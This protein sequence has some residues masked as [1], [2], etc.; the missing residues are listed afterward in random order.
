[1]QQRE[2]SARFMRGLLAKEPQGYF[3][4]SKPSPEPMTRA[5][6]LGAAKRAQLPGSVVFLGRPLIGKRYRG[7]ARS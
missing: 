2:R 3:R 7:G 4:I 1:V 6:F 5:R